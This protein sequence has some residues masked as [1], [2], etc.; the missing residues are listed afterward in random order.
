MECF[1]VEKVEE[2]PPVVNRSK[3]IGRAG[4][5]SWGSGAHS[6]DVFRGKITPW[7]PIPI[8]FWKRIQE[9]R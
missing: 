9:Q 7:N 3:P 2:G 5:P 1:R 8:G 4:R 6:G